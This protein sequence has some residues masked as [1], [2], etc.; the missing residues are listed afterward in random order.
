MEVLGA[1]ICKQKYSTEYEWKH[2]FRMEFALKGL[3]IWK[4]VS[5]LFQITQVLN[6]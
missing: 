2:M 4:N 6:V 3:F 5:E 1:Q